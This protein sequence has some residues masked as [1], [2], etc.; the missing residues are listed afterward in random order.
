[1]S[2]LEP[3]CWVN[4]AKISWGSKITASMV[5]IHE[6]LLKNQWTRQFSLFFTETETLTRGDIYNFAN[7]KTFEFLVK[8][9]FVYIYFNFCPC[10]LARK[11]DQRGVSGVTLQFPGTFFTFCNCFNFVVFFEQCCSLFGDR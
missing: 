11:I 6:L 8:K 9:P 4:T 7:S 5:K 3:T 10:I 2:N 1:M